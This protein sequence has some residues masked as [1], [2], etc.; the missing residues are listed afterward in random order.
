MCGHGQPEPEKPLCTGGNQCGGGYGSMCGH[1]GSG[2]GGW[3][4]VGNQGGGGGGNGN[5]GN[6]GGNMGNNGGSMGNNGG[7]MGPERQP[8]NYM[9]GAKKQEALSPPGEDSKNSSWSSSNYG[10]GGYDMARYAKQLGGMKGANNSG[11][12]GPMRQSGGNQSS[13]QTPYSR[14]GWN[15]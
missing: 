9:G 4:A 14:Q 10:Y 13:S 7:N 2:K 6:N 12:G 1:G 8:Q 15:Y 3:G 5:M 11:A